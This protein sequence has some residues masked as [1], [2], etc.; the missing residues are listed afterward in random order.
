[1]TD[2]ETF[3][4]IVDS[5]PNLS[6]YICFAKLVKGKKFNRVKITRLMNEL[7]DKKDYSS[8]DKTFLLDQLVN[9]SNE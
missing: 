5:Y 6:S 4:N 2:K 3:K 9:Y 7:V 1:M 8:S